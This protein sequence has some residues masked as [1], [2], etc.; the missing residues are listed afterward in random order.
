MS[1]AN[2]G[3]TATFFGSVDFYCSN[4]VNLGGGQQSCCTSTD[5]FTQGTL[6]SILQ[7]VT[8]I[9]R[10]TTPFA[11]IPGASHSGLTGSS[12]LT[13]PSCIGVLI[14]LTTVPAWVGV[15]AGSPTTLFEAGW[16]AWGNTDGFTAREF[17]SASPQL[18]LPN[19]AQQFTRLGYT[20]APG[21]VATIQELYAEP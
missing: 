12:V 5:P 15:E 21:V 18:S 13:I 7:L 8:L 16:I 4:G 17:I 19:E 14:T 10:N 1:N 20:I 6:N 11:Y 9:Q 2:S 3:C